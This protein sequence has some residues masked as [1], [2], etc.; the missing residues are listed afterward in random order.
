MYI[1]IYI[2][3]YIT[4]ISLSIYI[5]IYIH[6]YIY[7]YIYVYIYIYIYIYKHG[8]GEEAGAEGPGRHA[9]APLLGQVAGKAPGANI[10]FFVSSERLSIT[11]IR[12]RIHGHQWKK[13]LDHI[14]SRISK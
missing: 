8:E 9:R 14:G 5:H 6:M 7:I 10:V 4:Y 13:L 2:Y 12:S 11:S 1:Y 3:I